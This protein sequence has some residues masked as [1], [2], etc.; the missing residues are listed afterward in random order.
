MDYPKI[1]LL[2]G[3]IAS[4]KDSLSTKL[5][6]ELQS[7]GLT[8]ETMKFAEPLKVVTSALGRITRESIEIRAV[9]NSEL[10]ALDGYSPREYM[11]A[12]SNGMKMAFG[13]D[14][15]VRLALRQIM[16]LTLMSNIYDK[17]LDAIIIDDWRFDYEAD[18]LERLMKEE[19]VANPDIVRL[20]IVLD[21]TRFFNSKQGIRNSY[22][23]SLD[24]K[25][26]EDP[27]LKF[28]LDQYVLSVIT[29]DSE[30]QMDN[31]EGSL[32]FDHHIQ[33]TK[34]VSIE[35]MSDSL[36]QYFEKNIQW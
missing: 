23:T 14:H 27:K 34:D 3:K 12:L 36:I 7:Q 22:L 20:R 33:N 18:G 30:T 1:I 6:H 15:F 10:K 9:K 24:E 21:Q 31:L 28:K 29:D 13:Q 8:V 35:D 16:H 19:L 11:I 32:Y 4:G 26:L 25:D 5:K 17:G 2:S